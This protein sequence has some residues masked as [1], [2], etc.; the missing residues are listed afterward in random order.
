MYIQNR[1]RF[2]GIETKLAVTKGQRGGG[3]M[4]E[5]YGI[6]RYKLLCIKQISKKDLLYSIGN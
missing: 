2:P 3:R 5:Q 1:N 4:N 6:N